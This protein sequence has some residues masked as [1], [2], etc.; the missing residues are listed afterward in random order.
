MLNYFFKFL[1]S[2]FLGLFLSIS[3]FSNQIMPSDSVYDARYI[4]LQNEINNILNDYK[5]LSAGIALISKDKPDWIVGLG[6]SDSKKSQ[7]I[8]ENTIFRTASISKMFVALAIL[9]LHEGG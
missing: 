4:E 3:G 1:L 7:P 2:I 8:S 9:K 5:G 6:N